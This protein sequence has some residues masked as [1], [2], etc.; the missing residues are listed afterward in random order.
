M[1][2]TATTNPGT[3][4]PSEIACVILVRSADA[5]T[6]LHGPFSTPTAARTYAYHHMNDVAE[7]DITFGQ[8]R[9]RTDNAYLPHQIESACAVLSELSSRAKGGG[10]GACVVLRTT[11]DEEARAFGPFAD[12]AEAANWAKENAPQR[13]EILCLRDPSG[14]PWPG[15]EFAGVLD[16]VTHFEQVLRLAVTK[17]YDLELNSV[18]E[19]EC[20][21]CEYLPL[22]GIYGHIC[23]AGWLD[24]PT[25]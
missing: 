20:T 11:A 5:S 1:T 4:A 15:V 14:E 24:Y 22:V 8:F 7:A 12:P 16:A 21:D 13:G 25:P 19:P 23:N 18:G 9:T 10:G 3:T 17:S 2:V 6:Q